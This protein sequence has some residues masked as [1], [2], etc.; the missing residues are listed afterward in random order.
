VA[1]YRQGTDNQAAQAKAER[2]IA[3]FRIHGMTVPV[4]RSTLTSVLGDNGGPVCTHPASA[5][6][7]A[8]KDQQ[9]TNGAATVGSRPIRSS[10]RF[11]AGEVLVLRV[12]C[13]QK[14]PA[15]EKY[16]NSQRYYAVVRG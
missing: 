16:V 9:F 2:L 1:A 10:Q 12:Y 15:F 5:L 4:H 3:L 11:V 13:P 14:L 8:L 7:E 6:T